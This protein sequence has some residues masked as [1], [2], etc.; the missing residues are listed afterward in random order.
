MGLFEKKTNCSL[1]GVEQG[2]FKVADG[3][4]CQS[5]IKQCGLGFTLERILKERTIHEVKQAIEV[6]KENQK[7]LDVFNA[8]KVIG[9]FIQFDENNKLWLVKRKLNRLEIDPIIEKFSDIMDF[10][11]IEDG[12]S[13][14]VNRSLGE[15]LVG[16]STANKKIKKVVN[17]F[18]IKISLNNMITPAVF[19]DM[20]SAPT[21]YNSLVYKNAYNY[22]QQII[23]VL[24]VIIEN[25]KKDSSSQT[26]NSSADEIM[27]FKNL[28]ESGAISQEEYDAKK[29]QLLGL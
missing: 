7:K 12:D 19:I 22:A 27:K 9:E 16:I 8:T 25:E 5:C 28:L 26:N 17:K 6:Q 14:L 2:K 10:E 23:S 29:R 11:L 3:C 13:L 20:I 21:K 24:A 15:A 1:C 18:Q 4:I